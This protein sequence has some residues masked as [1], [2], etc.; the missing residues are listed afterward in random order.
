MDAVRNGNFTS[1]E[2]FNLM[3]EGKAKGSFGVP[4]LNYIEQKNIERRLG[5]GLDCESS[6][7]PLV[8]GKLLERRVFDLLGLEYSLCSQET[9]R[10][11]EFDYWYGSP[12][13]L[14]HDEQKA[15]IDIKCPYTLLSF[16]QL[17]ECK[18]VNELIDNHK[19]GEKYFW[20]L[21]SNA[22]LTDSDYAELIV[23][24]PYLSELMDI[25]AMA[26]GEKDATWIALSEDNDLPFLLDG[27]YY[28]NINILRFEVKEEVKKMLTDRVVEAGK[29]L[30]KSELLTALQ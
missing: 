3:K 7:K 30:T 16:V 26:A 4:A 14:R 1:S 17:V 25:R 23:Y 15:V 5:R 29:L 11:P 18:T 21:V 19:D 27:G 28:K 13:G 12:D 6:A 20:Q 10:H 2:I 8:W 9:I 22:I 24:A